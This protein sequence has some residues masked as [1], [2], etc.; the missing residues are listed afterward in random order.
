ML[1]E[2]GLKREKVGSLY[3]GGFAVHR[4]A[5]LRALTPSC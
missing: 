5:Y 2:W 1:E 4:R 3:L